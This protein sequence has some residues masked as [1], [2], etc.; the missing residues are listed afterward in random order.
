MYWSEWLNNVY[1]F[2]QYYKWVKTHITKE[3]ELMKM[4]P[5]FSF[6]I[7]LFL[8]STLNTTTSFAQDSPQWHLPDKARA[9]LGKGTVEEIAYSPDGTRLAVAGGMGIWIYDASTGTEVAFLV[10][11]TGYVHSVAY[12]P[13]GNT[14][15]SGGTGD[16]ILWNAAT[17]TLRSILR[18]HTDNVYGVAFS[19]DGRTIASGSRDDTVRL[20]DAATGTLKNTITARR[21]VYSV[22][23]SPDGRT[24]AGGTEY[25]GVH[26]WDAAT[27]TLK[28]TLEAAGRITSVVYSPDGTTLAAPSRDAVR[29]WDTATGNLRNTLYGEIGRIYSVAYS[30]DGTTLATA[31][32]GWRGLILWDAA[33]GTRKNTLTE[34]P[35]RVNSVAYSPDGTTLVG[36]GQDGTVVL[37]DAATGRQ[38][39]SLTGHTGFV[40]SIAYSPD[41]TTLASGGLGGVVRLW[42][43]VTGTLK[44]TIIVGNT[45]EPAIGRTDTHE[46][47][48]SIAYSPDGTTILS[49]VQ[50]EV[51]LWDVAT[52]T[53]KNTIRI[54]SA[55]AVYSPDGTTIGVRASRDVLWDVATGREKSLT[56]HPGRPES[57]LVFS[58]DS[59]TIAAGAGGGQ[60]F[61]WDVATGRHKSTLT[62]HVDTT[63]TSVA[64]SPDGTTLASISQSSSD[65]SLDGDK[66]VFLWD[67]ATFRVKH[68]LPGLTDY[69]LSM[70]YSPDG[71]TIAAGSWDGTVVLWDTASGRQKDV[72]QGHTTAGP[73]G[74]FGSYQVDVGGVYSVAF[75][76][77]GT[78][79]ASGSM[80]GTVLLWRL[81][82][83]TAPITFNPSTIADQTFTVGTPVSLTLPSATGGTP[84]YTYTLTPLLP[85]GL[86]FDAATRVLSG[87]PT[88]AT[89]ATPVTYTA[90]DSAGTTASLTFT[91]TV[92]DTTPADITFVPSAID[93][94][95]LTVNTPMDPLSLPRAEGG[96][97]PYTYTLDPLPVG[98]SFDAA[99]Q[100]LSGTP[101]TVGTLPAVYIATDATG[102][103][104]ALNFIIEVIEDDPG[105]DA[106]DVNGDGQVSVIDLAMV[107]LFYGTQVPAGFNLPADVNTD[108]V[109]NLADLAAVAQAIDAAGG[110][111]NQLSLQ[112]VE[113]ALLIAAEQAVELEAAAGAPSRAV[114]SV[115]VRFAT[116]NVADALAG[117]RTDVRFQKDFAV[118]EAF[119]A[120][121]T[122]LTATPE[123]TG[124]LPNYPNPFN[125]ETWIP[126]HLAT[127]AEVIVTIYD[128]R[129]VAVRELVFGH[130]P[131]GVYESRGRAAYWDGKNQHGEPVA[132]GVYFYTL[133]AGDFTATRKL[134][135]AK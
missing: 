127:D 125:P 42:D 124:L 130:Q 76:P 114:A 29:L 128:M 43:A 64:F 52:G 112:E 11:H 100:L 133:T 39:G 88:T 46:P 26:L 37:W 4:R 123:T 132:S 69:A 68:R 102:A 104:A 93:D 115:S 86:S 135:I 10:G 50:D 99:T 33:T 84:P 107:A 94:L 119:L 110:G 55:R 51:R 57:A 19:P 40:Y 13:D 54:S 16:V 71:S 126:Y 15:A 34:L 74:D 105:G 24:V 113:L 75:S 45:H 70:A 47:V 17:S 131:A 14:I 35:S 120:L 36:G 92:M 96:T 116:K 83:T 97:S 79:L 82:P 81:T 9:R 134:L 21:N 58:P 41:G 38:K 65:Y 109:V 23:F 59:R 12:S 32:W 87:T 61:L 7:V 22:A 66:E 122:E 62:G 27:G 121:L 117:A 77:D 53:L 95:T 85:A 60:V 73:R 28:N 44:D 103:S 78:T 49:G 90:T 129:G 5:N 6:L 80:D 72:L 106:L 18:G 63:V 3:N 2:S 20:W 108:G 31:G 101:T 56:G 25:G 30:P 118:L 89:P 98:L 67:V 91:I 8:V 1:L 48:Y 111:A